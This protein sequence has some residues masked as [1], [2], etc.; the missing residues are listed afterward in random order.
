MKVAK[1]M[2][3]IE[4]KKGSLHKELDIPESKNIP[5]YLLEEI[6]RARIGNIVE[7]HKVTHKLKTRSELAL[8]FRGK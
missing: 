8:R 6:D 2:Q 4:L 1:W 5:T 7:G 3:E